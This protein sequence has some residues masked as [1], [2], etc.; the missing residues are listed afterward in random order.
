M[1][2]SI[3]RTEL[4][5]TKT[6]GKLFSELMHIYDKG[7]ESTIY[8]HIYIISM[9]VVQ[10]IFYSIFRFVAF[11]D[12]NIRLLLF[13]HSRHDKFATGINENR[14]LLLGFRSDHY[15]SILYPAS[16]YKFSAVLLYLCKFNY[17]LTLLFVLLLKFVRH[18]VWS[19]ASL[20]LPIPDSFRRCL[21][22]FVFS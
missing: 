16:L 11:L 1:R 7:F 6:N 5:R 10:F 2:R 3:W 17:I 13:G 22:C 20:P 14:R 4:F 15:R 18:F 21:S 8:I 9:E 12:P 19:P